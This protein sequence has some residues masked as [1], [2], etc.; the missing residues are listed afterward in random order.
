MEKFLPEKYWRM[1]SLR[2]PETGLTAAVVAV[3]S[4]LLMQL[5]TGQAQAL[6]LS[7]PRLLLNT[8]DNYD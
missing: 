5:I 3:V 6:S 4:Q 2:W 8:D 7:L 1:L